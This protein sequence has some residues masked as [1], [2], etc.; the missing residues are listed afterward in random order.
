[1]SRGADRVDFVEQNGRACAVIRGNLA[2]LGFAEQ[3]HVYQMTAQNALSSLPGPYTLAFL[4]PPYDD[5]EA[6]TI[7]A[8]VAAA[9]LLAPEAIVCWEHAARTE[10]P[11]NVDGLALLRERRHG[12]TVVTLYSKGGT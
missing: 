10:A 9:P 3:A 11:A 4:D 6:L 12:D 1:L 2:A 8:N 7:L 5:P